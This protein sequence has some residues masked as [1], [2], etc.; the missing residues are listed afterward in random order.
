MP[1]GARW[2][3]TVAVADQAERLRSFFGALD[4]DR[5]V[6]AA[7]LHDI[8]YAAELKLTGF[9]PVDGAVWLSG[10][11]DA[12]VVGLVAHHSCAWMEA[13]LRGLGGELEK[14]PRPRL[15]LLDALTYCDMTSGPTGERV[16]LEQRLAEVTRRYGPGH[17]V[18]ASIE[19][20]ADYLRDAVTRTQDRAEKRR[21]G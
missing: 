3:H 11:V 16:T 9:H 12:E 10:R 18:T 6:A 13:D 17:L 8:G 7:Y 14:L 20:A 2:S 19:V 21:T 15:D 5:L 4:G 1:L